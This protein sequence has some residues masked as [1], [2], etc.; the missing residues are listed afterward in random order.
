MVDLESREELELQEQT[1]LTVGL[2]TKVVGKVDSVVVRARV[3]QEK[4]F[5][6]TRTR[7]GVV[8][9]FLSYPFSFFG[10]SGKGRRTWF[11]NLLFPAEEI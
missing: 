2:E 7:V 5:E 6:F 10:E 9:L 11:R 8:S 1:S 4:K 3:Q